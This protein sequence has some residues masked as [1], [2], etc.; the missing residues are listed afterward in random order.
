MNNKIPTKY[1]QMIEKRRKIDSFR[2]YFCSYV[3]LACGGWDSKTLP[4]K[5]QSVARHVTVQLLHGREARQLLRGR[6]CRSDSPPGG[7]RFW[8]VI[9]QAPK[10][11]KIEKFQSWP[12]SRYRALVPLTGPSVPLTGPPFPFQGPFNCLIVSHGPRGASKDIPCPYLGDTAPYLGD[13]A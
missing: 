7:A 2:P 12:A 5:W 9:P 3:C 8:C 1:D 6:E 13:S 10:G 11:P 4:H